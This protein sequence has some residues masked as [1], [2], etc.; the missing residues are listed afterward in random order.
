MAAEARNRVLCVDMNSVT[1]FLST[2]F[3][4]FQI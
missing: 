3:R 4:R 2:D 1:V